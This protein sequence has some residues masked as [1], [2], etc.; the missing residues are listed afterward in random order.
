MGIKYNNFLRSD[1][2][3][4]LRERKLKNKSRCDACGSYGTLHV[5][6]YNYEFKYSG[7]ASKAIKHTKVL[8]AGCHKAFHDKYG[9]KRNMQ[10]EM[11]EFMREAKIAKNIAM[12]YY[13]ELKEQEQW[14]K[15]F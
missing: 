14:I 6:H 12:K 5:H 11:D 2:W 8:C 9:V 3:K 7:R 4:F 15:Y 1:W 13:K 10:K